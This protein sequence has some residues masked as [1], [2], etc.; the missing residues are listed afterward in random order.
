M[1]ELER[2]LMFFEE[3]WPVGAREF[4]AKVDEYADFHWKHM[5]KEEKELMPLAE[6]YL[7]AEDWREI[8]EAFGMNH[9]PI[10]DLREKDFD[11]LF[12]RIVDLAPDPVGVGAPWSRVA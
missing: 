2:A 5:R 12:T 1:R 10:A 9:D 8:D 4:L 7:G 3:G 6:R 11:M